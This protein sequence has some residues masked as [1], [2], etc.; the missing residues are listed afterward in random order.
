MQLTDVAETDVDEMLT[1]YDIL[2]SSKQREQ[3]VI[4]TDEM[5]EMFNTRREEESSNDNYSSKKNKMPFCNIY[6]H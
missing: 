5:Y 1:V 3:Y 4:T 6:R 2:C